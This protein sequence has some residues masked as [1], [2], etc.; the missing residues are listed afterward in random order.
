MLLDKIKFKMTQCRSQWLNLAG[1]THLVKS[2]LSVLSI[3][4][5]SAISTTIGVVH[6]IKIPLRKFFSQGDKTTTKKFHLINWDTVTE[7]FDKAGLGIKNTAIM[8]VALGARILWR[9]V[10]GEQSWWKT[11]ITRKYL[12]PP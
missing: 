12:C 6:P 3:Y 1:R 9:L 11:V 4:L 2:V 10:L 7:P 8:N 5:F